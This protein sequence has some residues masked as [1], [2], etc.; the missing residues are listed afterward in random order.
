MLQVSPLP[1]MELRLELCRKRQNTSFHRSFTSSI[2]GTF[3][4]DEK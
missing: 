1:Q 4:D 3:K 2:C